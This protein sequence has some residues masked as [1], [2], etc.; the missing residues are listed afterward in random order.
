MDFDLYQTDVKKIKRSKLGKHFA[1]LQRKLKQTDLSMLIIIDGW[2]SSG[3]GYVLKDLTRKL[4]PRY[5]EVSLY[6]EPNV[7]EQQHT[8]LWKF[9]KHLPAKGE[10]AFFNRSFYFRLFNHLNL[11]AAEMKHKL[12]DI[13]LLERLLV[14]D[15]TL[16]V[17]LF[18]NHSEE[19][20]QARINELKASP[21][22]HFFVSEADLQ[23]LTFY[24]QYQQHMSAILERTSFSDSPWKVISTENKKQASR[25]A[26]QYCIEELEKHL[27]SKDFPRFE[28]LHQPKLKEIPALQ[29][30]DLDQKIKE[31]TYKQKRKALQKRAGELVY[32]LWLKQVPCV[33]VFEGTDAAGKGGAIKRLTRRMDPRHYDVATTASPTEYEDQYHYLWR[34]YRT[35]PTKGRM[36]IYDRSWYGRVLVERVE[37]FTSEERVY[38]AYAEI[39]EL[40]HNLV[41]E[42]HLLL[43]F[44]IVIDKETQRERLEARKNDP[45]KSY[46]LTDEDWRNHEK[47]YEYEKAFNDMLDHTSTEES[48]WT[49]VEGNQKKY[50]RIKVLETFVE[51]AERFLADK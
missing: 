11:S 16:V 49:V 7:V 48:P 20:M 50:A 32:Q 14:A 51:Q 23:Q 27:Q 45:E 1:K 42:G 10:I 12:M 47:F 2:E 19:T 8:F 29:A 41:H 21:H 31:E 5:Y 34:F 26:L 15:H 36:T 22:Q 46:K 40:E 35:F 25:V 6:E 17:K 13:S 9:M 38:D 39:N 3:K 4:D 18:L 37:G 43:K 33:I 30:V 24:K 28:A 44:L